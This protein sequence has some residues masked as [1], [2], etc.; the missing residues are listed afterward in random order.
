MLKASRRN[1]TASPAPIPITASARTSEAM[2]NGVGFGSDIAGQNPRRQMVIA[3]ANTILGASGADFMPGTGTNIST[4]SMRLK[5]SR[6]P[7]RRSVPRVISPDIAAEVPQQTRCVGHHAGKH[8]RHQHKQCD[9]EGGEPGYR[10][11]ARVLHGCN[12][13]NEADYDSDDKPDRQ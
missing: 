9:Q 10:A 11:E 3:S 5:Q 6:K 12:H 13:L 4:P 7:N 1:D 8:P 2:R